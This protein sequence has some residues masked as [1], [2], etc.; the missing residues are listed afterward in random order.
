[1][2]AATMGQP[3]RSQE[4][5]SHGPDKVTTADGSQRPSLSAVE[6]ACGSPRPALLPTDP[7][8][9]DHGEE[10]DVDADG[11]ESA[12]PMEAAEQM[13]GHD[14]PPLKRQK[15]EPHDAESEALDDEAVLALAAHN[16]STGPDP[17]GSDFDYHGEAKA[18]GDQGL[19][20]NRPVPQ[21][22]CNLNPLVRCTH[23]ACSINERPVGNSNLVDSQQPCYPQ[24]QKAKMPPKQAS[25]WEQPAFLLSLVCALYE[26][27]SLTPE[28]KKSVEEFLRAEGHNASWD[29]IRQVMRWTPE[30]HEDILLAIFQHLTLSAADFESIVADLRE[31]GY[32]FTESALRQHVQKL[33]RN[34]DAGGKAT[35]TPT[36][37]PAG[38]KKKAASKKNKKE[39]SPVDD[40]DEVKNLKREPED[41]DDGELVVKTPVKKRVKKEVKKETSSG[42]D[43]TDEI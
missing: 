5:P 39:M 12:G 17:Y 35:G 34:R 21:R 25:Q 3:R 23:L 6:A 20:S 4:P 13:E 32:S 8:P 11:A 30:V 24:Q 36:K 43:N 33:R 28:A 22:A 19:R 14:E 38:P 15:M 1:M 16:G 18:R 42:E 41:D 9:V 2:T 40:D 10:A 31:R 7:P 26:V 27:A 29:G 37:A